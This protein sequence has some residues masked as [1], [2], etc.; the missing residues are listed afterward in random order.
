MPLFRA[1]AAVLMRPSP[2][3]VFS[4]CRKACD[5]IVLASCRPAWNLEQSIQ[6]GK[7]G[8]RT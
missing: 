1:P 7:I 6:E 5:K 3:T 4:A 2:L 8:D